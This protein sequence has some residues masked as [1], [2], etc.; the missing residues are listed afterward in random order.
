[1]TRSLLDI[2]PAPGFDPSP[3]PRAFRCLLDAIARPGTV[4]RIATDLSPP[5][6]LALAA[7]ATLRRWST[8]RRR[9]GSTPARRAVLA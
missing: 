1:M 4:H 7:A 9:C 5:A 6:P 2:A 3:F 8:S